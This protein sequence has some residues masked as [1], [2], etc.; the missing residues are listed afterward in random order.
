MSAF[1]DFIRNANPEER[2]EVYAHVMKNATE[3]QNQAAD[4]VIVSK[5]LWDEIVDFIND[6]V[7]VRDGE[8]GAQLPNDAMSLSMRITEAGL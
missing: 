4:A 8:D 1:S 3:R 7:D 6:R 5:A 2:A